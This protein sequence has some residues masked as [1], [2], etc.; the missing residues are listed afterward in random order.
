MKEKKTFRPIPGLSREEEVKQLA[1]IIGVTQKNLER[2]E[3]TIK[4]YE[5]ELYDLMETYGPKDKA[6]LLMEG[7]VYGSDCVG[8]VWKRFEMLR[9]IRGIFLVAL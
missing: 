5:D 8:S 7:D 9:E 3:Q 4:Q 6:V 1:E 2:T